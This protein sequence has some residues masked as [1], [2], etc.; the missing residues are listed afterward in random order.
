MILDQS[1][2]DAL[3]TAFDDVLMNACPDAAAA[4]HDLVEAAAAVMA[5]ATYKRV[6]ADDVFLTEAE[7]YPVRAE[8]S[9]QPTSALG[10]AAARCL[11]AEGRAA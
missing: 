9:V 4:A 2:R 8:R 1:M 6:T 3:F 5:A 7:C 11:G 10:E